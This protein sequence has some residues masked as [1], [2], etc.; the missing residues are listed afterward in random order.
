VSAAQALAAVVAEPCAE[1]SCPGPELRVTSAALTSIPVQTAHGWAAAPAWLFTL[2]DTPIR[3]ARIAVDPDL[4]VYL[5]N[6]MFQPGGSAYTPVGHGALDR[7][8]TRLGVQFIGPSPGTGPCQ[9]EYVAHAVEGTSA[10]VAIVQPLP[11]FN[12]Q[13]HILCAPASTLLNQTVY[14][15]KPLGE[16]VLLEL[17]QGRPIAVDRPR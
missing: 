9:G 12:P 11:R 8:G 17:S 5:A 14:L 16:R 10:V 6:P 4:A 7:D 2:A 1:Q 3:L 15:S 13:Q